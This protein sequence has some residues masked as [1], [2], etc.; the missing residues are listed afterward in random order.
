MKFETPAQEEPTPQDTP[1]KRAS[2]VEKWLRG[3]LAAGMLL[4]G[5]GAKAET[6]EHITFGEKVAP[7]PE[8]VSS[9]ASK[10]KATSGEALQ[11]ELIKKTGYDIVKIAEE[12]GFTAILHVDNGTGQY[13][14]RIGQSHY[15]EASI[16]AEVT[17]GKTKEELY[18]YIITKK[19][20]IESVLLAFS[21]QNDKGSLTNVFQES[22]LEDADEQSS[23]EKSMEILSKIKPVPG[24]F[25]EVLNS[26]KQSGYALSTD[27]TAPKIALT[28]LHQKKLEELHQYFVSHPEEY[29]KSEQEFEKVKAKIV[30]SFD[31]LGNDKIYLAGAAHKLA[32]EGKVKLMGTETKAGNNAPVEVEN[33]RLKLFLHYQNMSEEDRAKLTEKEIEEFAKKVEELNAKFEKLAMH[34]RE[35]I[36]VNLIT[37]KSILLRQNVLLYIVGNLHKLPRAVIEFNEKNPKKIG[38]ITFVPNETE[39]VKK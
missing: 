34:D 13:I 4:G 8:L 30:N 32:V 3:A 28:H 14:I 7:V 26:F 5:V 17:A 38:L 39:S 35:D 24:C 25:Y 22:I 37:K 18:Q 20:K 12:A 16:E 21:V 23:Y 11:Q 29:K 6:D 31:T 10:E 19:K 2:G 36:A 33:E 27:S 15:S 9:S 1:Q